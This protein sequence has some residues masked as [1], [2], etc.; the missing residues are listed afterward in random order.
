MFVV[1]LI[2]LVLT[3]T[4]VPTF[5]IHVLHSDGALSTRSV[6]QSVRSVSGYVVECNIDVV[7]MR[8]PLD[9]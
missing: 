9:A 1:V 2:C 5:R 6:S 3:R 8:V 4:N 7:A